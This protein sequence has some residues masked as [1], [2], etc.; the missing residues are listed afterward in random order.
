MV[1]VERHLAELEGGVG[2]AGFGE[3][4]EVEHHFEQLVEPVVADQPRAQLR[5][6]DREEEVEIVVGCG[7]LVR[8]GGLHRA[9]GARRRVGDILAQRRTLPGRFSYH[10]PM[11]EPRPTLLVAVLVATL[12]PGAARADEVLRYHWHLEGLIGVL[13]SLFVP[14]RGDAELSVEKTPEGNLQSE[15]LITSPD[16]AAGEFF[17]YGAEWEPESG[18]TLEAWSAYRWRGEQKEKRAK[19]DEVGVVD[20]VSAI[21]LLRLVPPVE[22]RQLEIW[23]D[24][25]LYPV[26]VEPVAIEQV[27]VDK[28]T[29]AAHHYLVHGLDLPGRRKWD[30]ELELWI[31]LTRH[32][33]PLEMLV[34]RKGARLRLELTKLPD[35]EA[36][37]GMTHEAP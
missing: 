32:A 2:E 23:S 30:G 7:S 9:C 37:P 34:T 21:H 10:P 6:Q 29:L 35:P 36:P 20:I 8:L 11:R 33:T 4:A 16:S 18:R 19:V 31:S 5:G 27:Q 14:G 28:R 3:T 25:K 13:A 24:G 12:L 15:L 26:D 17:R 22:P 1:A